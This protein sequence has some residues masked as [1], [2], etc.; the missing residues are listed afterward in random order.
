MDPVATAPGA[1]ASTVNARL[2]WN[3]LLRWILQSSCGSL[4]SFIH[5]ALQGHFPEEDTRTPRP[6]WPIPVPYFVLAPEVDD[7]SRQQAAWQRCANVMV[8]CLN[9]L[10]F[11]R[12][13]RW[14]SRWSP[15][16]ALTIEHSAI[17]RR[18]RR[19]TG[20]WL[21]FA[22]VTAETMG[23]TAGK[24]ESLETM[25]HKLE[26]VAAALSPSSGSGKG[27]SFAAQ[28][29]EAGGSK[30]EAAQAAKPIEAHRLNFRGRPAF[31]PDR[32]LAEPARSLY[33]DPLQY[34]TLPEECVE[35]VPAVKVRGA[36]KEILALLAALDATGRLALFSPVQIRMDFRAGMF[37]LMKNLTTDR[38]I[39][40]CRPANLLEPGLNEWTQTMGALMPILGLHVPPGF[41]VVASG[42][43]LKD[44][45][46]Y[47]LISPVRA[48]RNALAMTLTR[49]EARR[50]R[51][52][53]R[54]ADRTSPVL[55]PALATMAMGDLNAV[56]FGQQAHVRLSLMH[57]VAKMLDLMTLRGQF[58]RQHWAAGF[59]IDDFIVVEAV[60]RSLEP[61]N[62]TSTR[63][64]DAMVK[65]YAEVGLQANSSKRFRA[66]KHPQFWGISIEGT[67][68]L[69]RAQLDRVIPM[70]FITARV[71]KV[72]VATRH[73]LQILAGAWTAIMQSRKRFMCLLD[74]L[75]SAIH[76]HEYDCLFALDVDTV[77][78]LWTLVSL[79][80]LMCSDLQARTS[81]HCLAVDASDHKVAGVS[82][83]LPQPFVQELTRH[84]MTR[85]AWSRL[86]SP[87]KT[88]QKCRGLLAPEDEVPDGEEP[89]RAHPVWRQICRSVQ[90][91]PLFCYQ[92]PTGQHI[93]ISEL[94]GCLQAERMIGEREP[95][96]RNNMAT[97]SQVA[98]GALVRGRSS[99]SSL[100]ELLKAHLPTLLVY[101]IYSFLQYV[102]SGDNPSDD[103]TRDVPL[104][105]PVETAPAWLQAAFEGDFKLLDEHLA[106]S[107]ADLATL[108]RLPEFV[109]GDVPSPWFISERKLRR[110]AYASCRGSPAARQMANQP[111]AAQPELWR[112]DRSSVLEVEAEQRLRSLP[113]SQFVFPRDWSAA[114]CREALHYRGA[115]DL[116]SGSRGLA[117]A[118][119]RHHHCWV[120]TYDILHDSAEDLLDD[121]V[122]SEIQKLVKL[123][124][125]DILTAGPV[126]SSFSRAVR[127]PVRSRSRPRGFETVTESMKRKIHDGN[128]FSVWLA[129]LVWLAFSCGV[130]F[131]IENPWMS[132]LWDQPEWK[133]LASHERVGFFT[134]D[135]CVWGAPWRKR[136]SFLTNS[137]LWGCKLLCAC[138][139][140]INHIQL[141]GYSS[142]N[143]MP[144][145][146]V[147]E[148]YP[149]RLCNTLALYLSNDCLPPERQRKLDLAACARCNSRVGE[150]KKPGPR[151]AR[152]RPAVDLENVQLLSSHTLAIQQRA[153]SLFATW[154]GR[155]LGPE[156][157][158][159][160]STQPELAT[161]LLRAFGR[162]LFEAQQPL[163]LYRQRHFHVFPGP[164]AE[165]WDLIAR[166]ERVQPVVH[167]TPMPKIIFDAM[168]CLAWTW[169]WKRWATL[170]LLAFH[171]KLRV[172]EPLRARRKDLLL[173]SETGSDVRAVY[174][175]IPKSKTSHRGKGVVQHTRINDE[176]TLLAAE[177]I[178]GPLLPD[179]FLY[180]TTPSTYRR[181]WDVLLS[182]L[183]I[184][185]AIGL[186]PG[187]LRSGGAIF[188][189]HQGTAISEIQWLMRLKSVNTLES[190]LQETAAMN[191]MQKLPR[192]VRTRVTALSQLLPFVL[193]LSP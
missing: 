122:Q 16:S 5:S 101:N 100:N 105:A 102:P 31:D 35:N 89:A 26:K 70:A 128:A 142:R 60:P 66:D 146:K 51:G 109:E 159:V 176:L 170:T 98:L 113:L 99:S 12:P 65:V 56:E 187:T 191:V 72:G 177:R 19:L 168:I 76:S 137:Y 58:P 141:K 21:D 156:L 169:R 59:V 9:W 4:R 135:C 112:A 104:R 47:Y 78:E 42:E 175:N 38:L 82:T 11:S 94:N 111:Q 140:P 32:Y 43:D 63:V 163:Y 81:S 3:S 39:L 41:H 136:T 28:L 138:Q 62:Y 123:K 148:A 157:L 172:S 167:R 34:A 68:C 118:L 57:G 115:L 164:L 54:S 154:L 13:H 124:C 186:T 96:S 131:L 75:F 110:A 189:Y 83:E 93:N 182:T 183:Q 114:R 178:F 17:L 74:A 6:V 134:T 181:R 67:E 193:R 44:Y 103:P 162:F 33:K 15:R 55:V 174:L 91:E 107:K 153:R 23:R 73:L 61:S 119:A 20:E 188:A 129:A 180:P 97:D 161:P 184:D 84:A 29:Q 36:R 106:D 179:D 150:A 49:A 40:D 92:V 22:D 18:L 158:E 125:F 144:W 85:S 79:A 152:P 121:L 69:V 173:A 151:P 53:Y 48:R 88:Y 87:W 127:P 108:A 24:V 7:A 130:I 165:A 160:F 190:Y 185:A 132:F 133:E 77:A 14:P 8:L 90:F 1:K 71:A 147:A 10:H 64:A 192:D 37:A 145:T 117:R 50:F 46:Y 126:C 45:Y 2:L 171:G 166:W 139:K 25:I 86:L 95:D 30:V 155:V 80:P 143:K 116:F 120:L 149:I 27:P 52:A